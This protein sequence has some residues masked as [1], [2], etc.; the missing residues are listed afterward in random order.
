M[1]QNVIKDVEKCRAQK[2]SKETLNYPPYLY[3][4]QC[5]KIA[6]FYE[7]FKQ[8]F[9]TNFRKGERAKFC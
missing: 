1:S 4:D 5:K 2:K 8:I 6:K 9:Y 7:N 3:I